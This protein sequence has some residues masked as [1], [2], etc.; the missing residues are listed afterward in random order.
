MHKRGILVCLLVALLLPAWGCQNRTEGQDLTPDQAKDL[1][2]E[3]V[4]GA[5]R[6]DFWE[7]GREEDAGG[8]VYEGRLIYDGME[9]EFEIDGDSGAFRQWDVERAK[10]MD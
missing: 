6:E 9:Y 8:T 10:T 4:K 1:V 2:L 3:R 7:F 5:T